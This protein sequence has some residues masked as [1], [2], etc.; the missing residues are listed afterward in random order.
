MNVKKLIQ[1]DEELC[2]GCGACIAPCV[3]GALALID[4][5]A[6]VINQNFCDGAGVCLG[7][8]PTGALSLVPANEPEIVQKG[9]PSNVKDR[10]QC[11]FCQ[12]DEDQSYLISLQ[13]KGQN[14]LTCTKCLPALIHG[15]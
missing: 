8:C 4:G 6:R 15:K 9:T 3:E 13:H 11:S 12:T 10:L 5:K 1:I 7:S 2:D 14:L